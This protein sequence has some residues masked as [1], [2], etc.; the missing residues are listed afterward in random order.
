MTLVKFAGN[1]EVQ[2]NY[3]IEISKHKTSSKQK[4]NILRVCRIHDVAGRESVCITENFCRS[5][6][7]LLTSTDS[8]TPPPQ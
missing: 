2:K 1:Y 8:Y 3:L 4:F 6:T 7:S 5:C